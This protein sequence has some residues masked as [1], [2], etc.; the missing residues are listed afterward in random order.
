VVPQLEYFKERHPIYGIS[1]PALANTNF[2]KQDTMLKRKL[3]AENQT[4]SPSSVKKKKK[5]N[6]ADM[7]N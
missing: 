5:K 1:S 4:A 7:E 2:G 3:E 6:K